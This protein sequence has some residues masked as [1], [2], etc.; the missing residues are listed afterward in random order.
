MSI[1][2]IWIVA[3]WLIEADFK[4]YWKRFKTTPT[5]WMLLGILLWGLLSLLW[6]DDV[7]YGLKDL[8]RKMPFFAIPFALGLSKPIEKKVL[9]FLLYLFLGI[10]TLTS[11]INFYRYHFVIEGV[12]VREMSFFISHV[13][14][15]ILTALGVFIA[16][17]LIVKRSKLWWLWTIILAWLIFYNIRSQTLTAYILM[18]V[19]GLFSALYFISK[20]KHKGLKW[21]LNGL[22]VSS[23]AGFVWILSN[24]VGSY[25]SA[26]QLTYQD[27]DGHTVNGRLYHHDLS[28][29][30]RENGNH[31]WIYVQ[32]E[33][34]ESEWNKRSSIPYMGKDAKGQPMF[35]TILR[36]MTSKNLRKDSV[37]VWTLTE[38]EIHEIENGK[39]SIAQTNSLKKKLHEFIYQFEVYQYQGDPNGHSLLQRLEHLRIAWR[40]VRDQP[41]IGVG[42]GD[43]P[44][45]FEQEYISSESMLAEENRHRSHNQYLTLWISHGIF[46]LLMIVGMLFYPMLKAKNKDYFFWIVMLTL[47]ISMLFQDMLETQ[48]GVTIFGLFYGL[49]VYREEAKV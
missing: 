25:T 9:Y 23:L 20:L 27:L 45:A 44:E 30:E 8:A 37:G 15:G 12:D 16:I 28:V 4:D 33:E 18:A 29:Q 19:L 2:A 35:G 10:L 42:M 1:G 14:F 43:V 22:I 5:V 3:N 41:I 32:Q 38:E 7:Q 34:L 36:Y 26:P 31:V 46:G 48:A 13:R 17:Y 6:S 21:S 47:T 39:T 24:A 49:A 40:I 11:A